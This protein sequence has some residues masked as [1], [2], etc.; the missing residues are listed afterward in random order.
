[1]FFCKK[2]GFGPLG[3]NIACA[4]FP[5]A[6]AYNIKMYMEQASREV[7]C[8]FT[9]QNISHGFILLLICSNCVGLSFE[10]IVQMRCISN[11]QLMHP[12]SLKSLPI[13]KYIYLI[14]RTPTLLFLILIFFNSP[15]YL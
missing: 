14:N 11:F 2:K 1:M 8:Y 4:N 3:F 5:I 10:W 7:K 6:C 12:P 13:K 15:S 9:I